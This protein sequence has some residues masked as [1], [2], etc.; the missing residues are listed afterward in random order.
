M[1]FSPQVS[2]ERLFFSFLWLFPSQIDRLVREP[3]G[4]SGLKIFPLRKFLGET[5]VCSH[6]QLFKILGHFPRSWGAGPGTWSDASVS[7]MISLRDPVLEFMPRN[8]KDGCTRTT[9]VFSFSVSLGTLFGCY[10]SNWRKVKSC[11]WVFP[12]DPER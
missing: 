3:C 10:F 12:L 4:M 6:L 9:N 5:L 7:Q 1:N 11:W 2:E 8:L